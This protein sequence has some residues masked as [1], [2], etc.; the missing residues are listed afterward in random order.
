M[1]F[2][3]SISQSLESNDCYGQAMFAAI[4]TF[5]VYTIL[6]IFNTI[7]AP[8]QPVYLIA[9]VM[10]GV[11]VSHLNYITSIKHR[12]SIY[13]ATI[14]FMAISISA[15]TLVAYIYALFLF[16]T[17]V[18][19]AAAF[20][21]TMPRARRSYRPAIVFSFIIAFMSTSFDGVGSLYV[22]YNRVATIFLGGLLGFVALQLAPLDP[23]YQMWRKALALYLLESQ[24]RV[25]AML[26]NTT[27][28]NDLVHEHAL[29]LKHSLCCLEKDPLH[30]NY[31][32]CFDYFYRAVFGI[33][34]A[35]H[36]QDLYPARR[37]RFEK[38]NTSLTVMVSSIR[39]KVA[40]PED[41]LID[42]SNIEASVTDPANKNIWK[43]F[44]NA[45]VAWNKIC[46]I[47][48]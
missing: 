4:M 45:I 3:R 29:K 6:A 8:T 43:S 32:E 14:I 39:N 41:I 17:F 2:V 13:W 10:A 40:I 5:Y 37:I 36:Q 34:Y 42:L 38:L 47:K 1:S 46:N 48:I 25:N 26:Y 44:T 31:M 28:V 11:G 9:P 27:F 30:S 7:Y 33:V 19:C 12:N 22:A 18:L 24:K 35:Q 23:Y 20:I 16:V 15:F 21:Y